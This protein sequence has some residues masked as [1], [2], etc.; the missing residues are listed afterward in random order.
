MKATL[1]LVLT[2]LLLS[3]M[4]PSICLCTEEAAHLAIVVSMV[5]D[6]AKVKRFSQNDLESPAKVGMKLYDKDTVITPATASCSL[7]FNT[8]DMVKVAANSRLTVNMRPQDSKSLMSVSRKLAAAFFTEDPN[9]DTLAAVGGVRAIDTQMPV[10]LF[11]KESSIMTEKPTFQWSQI[12]GAKNYIVTLTDSEGNV[13]TK[14][15][16]AAPKL[17]YPAEFPALK[18]GASYFWQVDVVLKD[19]KKSSESG[20][21]D[22]I[23]EE[24]KKEIAQIHASLAK[25]GNISELPF[26]MAMVY[27][28]HNMLHEAIEQYQKMIESNPN[29]AYPY[30]QLGTLYVK[31]G[32]KEKAIEVFSKSAQLDPESSVAHRCLAKLYEVTG[33][34]EK[35]KKEQG[36]VDRMSLSA[37]GM[38]R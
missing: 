20:T 9:E 19:T 31:L 37:K 14:E 22:L 7:M 10:L 26:I 18:Q 3:W 27:Q 29:G 35:A 23:S 34:S 11:P 24:A 12:P 15:G 17:E 16:I 5:G 21:F 6:G 30:E 25:E 38:K 1:K 4:V 28:K 33:E 2:M 13:W 36:I 8:G 32:W